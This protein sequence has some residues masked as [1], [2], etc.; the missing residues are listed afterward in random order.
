M[1]QLAQFSIEQK[2]APKKIAVLISGSGTN[3]QALIDNIDKINGT[4]DVVI[5]NRKDAYGLQRAKLNNIDNLYINQKNYK[6]VEAFNDEIIN[7]L[8]KRNID[9]VVLAGYLKILSKKFINCYKNR[10]IN[11]HPSLI[12]SFCGNGFY[13]LRVHEEAIKYGVKIS[14]ATVHF[15]DEEADTGAIILQDTVK[16]DDNDTAEILQ[17]KVLLIEHTLLPEAVKLFCEEKLHIENRRVIVK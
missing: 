1:P 14:G 5:S 13:G 17:K 6:S 12:P 4:I 9:L 10:I 16:I 2:V 11:I 3:L 7:E 15:V 8:T